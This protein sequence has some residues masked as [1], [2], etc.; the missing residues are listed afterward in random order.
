MA[1]STNPWTERTAT[2]CV[3]AAE[4]TEILAEKLRAISAEMSSNPEAVGLC[5]LW[6]KAASSRAS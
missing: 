2:M 6:D 1:A 3:E 4:I 5:R